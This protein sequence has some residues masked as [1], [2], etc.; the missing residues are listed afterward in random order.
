MKHGESTIISNKKIASGFYKLKIRWETVR[1]TPSPGQFLTLRICNSTDPL[2]RRPFAFSAYSRTSQSAEIIY[3]IRGKTTEI[4]SK[5]QSGEKIDIIGPLGKGF[6][7]PE[8]G[9]TP[10]LIAGGVGLGPILYLY[11]HFTANSLKP[12]LISGFQDSS[13]I[14]GNDDLTAENNITIC[15]DNGSYGF[16]GT[17]I[18]FLD[19]ISD[20]KLK[21]STLY[22]CGPNPMMKAAFLR[23][24]K[25][26]IECY[27]S[28][29]E[30]MACGVGACMGCALKVKDKAA[31]VRVCKEGPVFRA[32]EL[33]WT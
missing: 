19:T 24:E 17:T 9:K 3:Q 18:D 8:N 27:V 21:I 12:Q 15:T 22:C 33:E 10:I 1:E 16:K 32:G 7:Y 30:I 20:D 5:M 14:P 4:L 2:L 25:H 28:M 6:P 26:N 11:E 13:L 31:Y 29:E 23:A